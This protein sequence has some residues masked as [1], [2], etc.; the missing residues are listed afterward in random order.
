MPLLWV[1][2]VGQEETCLSAAFA[3]S[4]SRADTL[5]PFCAVDRFGLWLKSVDPF[6][7]EDLQMYRITKYTSDI[8]VHLSMYEN[9]CYS[10][11]SFITV[12]NDA[13]QWLSNNVQVQSPDE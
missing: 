13:V 12:L 9:I 2:A 1:H 8:K 11:M 5:S 3:P 6:S 10:N 4:L 7:E